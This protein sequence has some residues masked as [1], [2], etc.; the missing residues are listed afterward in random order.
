MENNPLEL[1]VLCG[2]ETPYR[3]NDHVDMRYNYV[4]GI[5]QMCKD[6][7]QAGTDRDLIC[8][9]AST[10]LTKSNNYDLGEEVRR[11]YYSDRKIKPAQ[12]NQGRRDKQ[13]ADSEK[14]IAACVF[15]AVVMFLAVLAY[16][17]LK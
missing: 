15:G 12:T 2:K 14:I 3:F 6:C 8:V 10:I 4:S 7:Y 11:M 16:E 5:G 9:P 17:L 13:T 1:C